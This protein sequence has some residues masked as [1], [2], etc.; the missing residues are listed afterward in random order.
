[1]IEL[2]TQTE[3]R[4]PFLALIAEGMALLVYF[5]LSIR[6]GTRYRTKKRGATRNLFLSFFLYFV[7][8]SFLFSTKTTDFLTG[9]LYNVS[10]LGINLGYAFSALGNMFLFYFTE[11]IF[12]EKRKTY[13]R[14]AITFANGITFGFLM[15]FIF[16]VQSIPFLEIPGTYIPPH[17]LIW[18][19]VVST[20]GFMILFVKAFQFTKQSSD[21]VPKVGFS[22]IGLSAFFE[23]LVFAFFFADRFLSGGF[24]SYYF[25]AWL[26]A[27]LAGMCS[28]IGYLMPNWFKKLVS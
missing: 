20:I 9:D 7:A 5:Y 24:T 12:F 15:I 3:S 6:L 14:E 1:M 28:M 26:S 18:H 13:M 19:V 10:N 4:V 22:M 27:S 16:Q 17:L 8:I 11:D 23:L 2:I 25:M 21:R